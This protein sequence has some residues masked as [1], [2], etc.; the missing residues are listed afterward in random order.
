MAFVNV[1]FSARYTE[2]AAREARHPRPRWRDQ[3]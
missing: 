1:Q 3:R 2:D